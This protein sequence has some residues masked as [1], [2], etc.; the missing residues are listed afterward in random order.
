M[1]IVH[2]EIRCDHNGTSA[3]TQTPLVH[4]N[5]IF[6]VYVYYT[7]IL[8]KKLFCEI[9]NQWYDILTII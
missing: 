8:H 2:K 9:I 3:D 7:V 1:Y 4:L 5:N 6:Y